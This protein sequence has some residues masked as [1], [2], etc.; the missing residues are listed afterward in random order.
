MNYLNLIIDR[1]KHVGNDRN[2]AIDVV[3]EGLPATVSSAMT[4][5][6]PDLIY[7]NQLPYERA[8]FIMRALLRLLDEHPVQAIITDHTLTTSEVTPFV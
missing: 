7:R 3:L 5:Y 1:P 8:D 6:I 4:R 2:C